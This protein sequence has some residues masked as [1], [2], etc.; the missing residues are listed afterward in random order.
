MP[1]INGLF[2]SLFGGDSG[3][4]ESPVPAPPAPQRRMSSPLDF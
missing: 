4:P 2:S 1:V 3:T